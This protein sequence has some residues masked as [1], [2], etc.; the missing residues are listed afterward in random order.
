MKQNWIIEKFPSRRLQ[1]HLNVQQLHVTPTD[2]NDFIVL[3]ELQLN[4]I[5]AGMNKHSRNFR[6]VR[7]VAVDV[8]SFLNSIMEME[9][10]KSNSI[11]Y[12][13]LWEDN[14]WLQVGESQKLSRNPDRRKFLQ[15][16]SCKTSFVELWTEAFGIRHLVWCKQ[17]PQRKTYCC[18]SGRG[19]WHCRRP[20]AF[21]WLFLLSGLNN[22]WKICC[23]QFV[24]KLGSQ[25]RNMQSNK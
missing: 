21:R 16:K 22:R 1:F 15:R 19:K 4:C 5:I 7:F 9:I 17:S 10:Q 2:E 24:D 18:Q 8:I 25:N 3:V 12:S 23:L 14:Y 11:S 13:Q 6:Q 20:F